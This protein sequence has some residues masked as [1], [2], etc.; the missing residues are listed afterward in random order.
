MIR[1][2]NRQGI[3]SSSRAVVRRA[4]IEALEA[5]QMLSVVQDGGLVRVT[6]TSGD[7]TIIVSRDQYLKRTLRISVNGFMNVVGEK[8]LSGI[9]IQGLDG[10]DRILVDE[11]QGAVGTPIN[12]QG[13]KGNDSMSGGSGPDVLSGGPGNDVMRGNAGND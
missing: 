3:S 6:G 4:A 7:D 8:G 1:R 9:S 10:N 13:G 11:S 5:R 12:E 2:W